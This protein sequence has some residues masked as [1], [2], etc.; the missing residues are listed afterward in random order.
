MHYLQLMYTYA[1][2]WG[3]GGPSRLMYDYARWMANVGPGASVIAGDIYHDYTGIRVREE[4]LEGIRIRR[5]RVYF[6]NLVKRSFNCVAPSMLLL[7]LRRVMSLNQVTVIHIAELRSPVFLYAAIL[8]RLLPR[9]VVLLHSAFGMLHQRKS[10]LRD[11]FD[12]IFMGFMLRSVDVGLAQNDHEAEVYR[13]YCLRYGARH[14]RVELLPLHS[15]GPR[16]PA[17]DVELTDNVLRL[18]LRER[19]SVPQD[20]LVCIFLGRL[21]ERKGLLRTIDAFLAYARS[22]SR[23]AL[24]LVVGRDDGFQDA[25]NRHIDQSGAR[26]HVRVVNGVYE[27]RFD[28]YTLADVFLGFPTIFEETM[29]SSVEALSCGTPVIVSREADLP[30][31]ESGGAGFVVD[32]SI[33]TV[34]ERLS[35][36]AAAPAAYRVNAHAVAKAHFG[37]AATCAAFQAIIE[38]AAKAR[39]TRAS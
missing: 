15:P 28:Y 34:T 26:E 16:R 17:P 18:R 12:P 11:L 29:L 22:S 38:A 9:Q 21:H 33:A 23:Q 7:G 6:R 2:A 37:E 36:I 27:D 19:Y 4:T 25:I 10:R 3:F 31:V 13:D 14:T 1:P 5:V 20:A 30:Y 39:A 35:A 24:L 8:R 32:F